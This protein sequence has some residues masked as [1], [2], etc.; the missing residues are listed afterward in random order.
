MLTGLSDIR[1]ALFPRG[2]INEGLLHY[3][4][5]EE[6][7]GSRVD[8]LGGT[9]LSV[10]AGSVSSAA[11]KNNSGASIAVAN[12]LG[13][14]ANA[15]FPT[16]SWTVTFWLKPTSFTTGAQDTPIFVSTSGNSGFDLVQVQS[17]TNANIQL[18]PLGAGGGTIVG[19]PFSTGSF[20]FIAVVFN[21]T[22]KTGF[23]TIDTNTVSWGPTGG[24]FA[25]D[26]SVMEFSF[27]TTLGV[28][29][30]FDELAV[31]NRTLS[32]SEITTLYNGGA[33]RFYP[34]F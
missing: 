21:K 27:T 7:S 24:T 15:F 6:S 30:V 20:H 29:G 26:S 5:M 18:W 1:L 32:P 33:G 23:M 22:A 31:W 4:K 11:G 17:S 10:Q 16:T 2:G 12:N 13:I 9:S 3:Y 19:D 34:T 14:A 28:N 8:S 25:F